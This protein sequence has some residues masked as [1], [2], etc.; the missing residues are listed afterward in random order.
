MEMQLI[1]AYCI[2]DDV[3][4]NLKI[5][6]DPQ[7]KM[8]MP[9]IMVTAIAGMKFFGGNYEKSRVF[10]KEYGYVKN[11]L[12]KS[13]F[14]RRLNSIDQ[15]IWATVF[16]I[17]SKTFKECNNGNEFVVDSFP[18]PVCKNIRITRSKIYKDKKYRGYSASKREFFY[19]LKV[20]VITTTKKQPVEIILAPGSFH[21]CKVFKDFD[22]NLPRNSFL[23]A[24]A[25]YN[26]YFFEDLVKEAAGINLISQRKSNSRRRQTA[27]SR[28]ICDCKRKMIETAFSCIEKLLPRHIHAVT[29][30]GFEL[31]V[32]LFVLTY[33]F[34]FLA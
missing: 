17:L 34:S 24:D 27:A 29:A 1:I 12:S 32:F 19:G 13:Q 8:T 20:H 30:K 5:Q 16:A 23:Y 33:A 18:I 14:N 6:E 21:D 11:M 4:K 31:K 15:H 26:D 22:F 3:V 7:V 10:M 9:E 2:C 28:F 25:A